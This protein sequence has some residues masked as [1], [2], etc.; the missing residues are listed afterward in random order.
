[1]PLIFAE[2]EISQSNQI[3]DIQENFRLI[4]KL[5]H[6]NIASVKSLGHDNKCGYFIVME[7]VDGISLKKYRQA[8]TNRVLPL[9]EA[10][11]VIKQ[12]ACGIDYAYSEGVIHRDLKPENIIVTPDS[13]V[14]IIDF[15]IAM[16]IKSTYT[17]LTSVRLDLSGT[18]PYMSPEQ[19]E[20]ERQDKKTDI[21]SLGV[22]FYEM[23]KGYCPFENPDP[24][25]LG[26]IVKTKQPNQS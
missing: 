18:W 17:R 10:E 7:F 23:V 11:R 16:E 8:Q 3:G 1:M 9:D 13:K 24:I 19:W 5:N 22:V 14:K 15:G 2:E 21:Y 26:N 12:V 20:G 6:P 4:E 25:I